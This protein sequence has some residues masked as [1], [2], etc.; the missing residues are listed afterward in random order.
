MN[1]VIGVLAL[2]VLLLTSGCAGEVLDRPGTFR[3]TGANDANLRAMVADPAHLQHGEGANGARGA[4]AASPV[5][6]LLS[7]KPRPLPTTGTTILH[8]GGGLDGAR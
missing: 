6:L 7:G 3:A 5:D 4:A 2:L 1:R 8:S